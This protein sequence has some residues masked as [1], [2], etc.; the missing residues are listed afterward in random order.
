[1]RTFLSG[2]LL[3]FLLFS[4]NKKEPAAPVKSGLVPK[5]ENNA[6]FK[7]LYSCYSNNN[8]DSN[9]MADGL[10]GTWKLDYSY[11]Y[12]TADATYAD[13]E[14]LITFF[15]NRTLI[16]KESGVSGSARNWSLY[17]DNSTSWMLQVNPMFEYLRG[18]IFLCDT[19]VMFYNSYIDGFDYYFTKVD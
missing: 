3:S 15:P 6:R 14:V 19:E 13:K 10:I 7:A 8:R 11:N 12:W 5:D 17:L 9:G 1:M 18:Q 16:I 2:F 4:C